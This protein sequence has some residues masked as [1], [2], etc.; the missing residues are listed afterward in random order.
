MATRTIKVFGLALV[1][2]L[3]S[4]TAARACGG[5]V[6]PNGTIALTR[7]TTLAGYR[8]GIEHYVTGFEF[9]GQADEV[10]SIVPLPGR[11]ARVIRG[12]D[13]TLQRLAQEVAPR[14]EESLDGAVL[15]AAP[16]SAKVILR[17]TIDALDVVIL[18]GGG[19]AVGR[20][21]KDHGFLLPPDA[22]EVLDFY[23]SRSP[24]FM[25]ARFDGQKA[26]E[27]GQGVGDST[28]VHLV[29]PTERPWVPLRILG[30][31][32]DAAAVVEANVFLLT[33]DEPRMLPVPLAPGL[34][35][36]RA[37]GMVLA[38]SEPAS[39]LLISD[40]R[41]DEHM[42]WVDGKGMWLSYL[43]IDER[44]GEL[45]HDLAI[46]PTGEGEPSPVDAGLVQAGARVSTQPNGGPV[47]WLIAAALAALVA[48]TVTGL[49]L[50]RSHRRGKGPGLPA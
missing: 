7:T 38:R 44:A 36:R 33:D 6:A 12:G 19:D 5:L 32:Q 10:G 34:E 20:W 42:K 31:G 39:E 15:S 49:G 43:K 14:V 3:A 46:N 30:L 13:W 25:A 1:V 4:A 9:A 27:L 23:A 21:A 11:P 22:P 47:G 8:N 35:D 26:N 37:P 40:L 29:I 24:Y 50:G 48:I 2:L 16:R 17:T 18:E 28:P 45:H 41:S